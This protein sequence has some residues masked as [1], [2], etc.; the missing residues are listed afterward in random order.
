MKKTEDIVAVGAGIQLVVV[1]MEVGMGM[2]ELGM[3]DVAAVVTV[4][5]ISS[6]ALEDIVKVVVVGTEVGRRRVV[7]VMD[8]DMVEGGGGKTGIEML[9]KLG[10][11]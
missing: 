3:G 9:V 2:R 8:M 5:T 4:V 10:L 6:V 1:R 7:V 11:G